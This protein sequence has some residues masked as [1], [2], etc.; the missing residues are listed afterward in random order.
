ME[1]EKVL[2]GGFPGPKVWVD[3]RGWG[4]GQGRFVKELGAPNNKA[5]L[6]SLHFLWLPVDKVLLIFSDK[7]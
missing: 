6:G 1:L 5:L 2:E 4:L 3:G 7:H